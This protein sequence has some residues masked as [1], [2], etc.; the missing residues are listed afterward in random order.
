[1]RRTVVLVAVGVIAAVVIATGSRTATSA[2]AG[3]VRVPSSPRD[4]HLVEQTPPALAV[5]WRAVKG[6]SPITGYVVTANPGDVTCSTTGA[7]SCTLPWLGP[8][9]YTSVRVVASD[10]KGQGRPSKVVGQVLPPTHSC[11]YVASGANLYG[12]HLDGVD[13]ANAELSDADMCGALLGGSDLN[14]TNLSDVILGC[15]VQRH[16]GGTYP[17]AANGSSITGTPEAMPADWSLIGGWLLGPSVDLTAVDIES[18]DLSGIDISGANLYAGDLEYDNLTG[19]DLTDIQLPSA[20]L[21][22]DNFTGAN[23]SGAY[24]WGPGSVSP[25]PTGLYDDVWDDTTCPDGTNSNDDDG[26]CLNNLG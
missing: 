23:L 17:V 1:M 6:G 22:F 21:Y 3:P 10:A 9:A 25:G 4:I 12:C 14:D 8:D 11:S 5:S 7:T 15:E 24:V 16:P 13:L 2:E 18:L 20:G 19:A 26:T